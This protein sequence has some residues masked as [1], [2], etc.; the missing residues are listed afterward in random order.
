MLRRVTEV[1]SGKPGVIFGN[2]SRP[3]LRI[4]YP[5]RSFIPDRVRFDGT[6]FEFDVSERFADVTNRMFAGSGV[7][8]TR[9]IVTFVRWKY[10]INNTVD[11][12]DWQY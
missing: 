5:H 3:H 6:A 1:G 8:S 9:E 10:N 4:R 7:S 11:I 2:H 12:I